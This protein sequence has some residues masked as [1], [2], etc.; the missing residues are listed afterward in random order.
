MA[1]TDTTFLNRE[2]NADVL[3]EFARVAV[4]EI[5]RLSEIVAEL[6]KSSLDREQLR[7]SYE[8]RLLKL[9]KKLFGRGG[10]SIDKGLRPKDSKDL[11]LHGGPENPDPAGQEK[12]KAKDRT[13]AREESTL[14][15]MSGPELKDE[16]MSRGYTDAKASDWEEVQGLYDQSTEITVVE[17]TYKK[18]T[19]KRKKY[20]F[21]PSIGTDKE[22]IVTAKGPEK[23]AP[24]CT[25]SLDFAIAVTCDKY[26]WHLPL[27]RQIEIMERLG[28]TGLV[29]KTLYGLID[30]LSSQVRRSGVLEKIRQDILNAPLA[31]HADETPWPVLDGHD[32][33]GYLWAICNMRGAYYRFEPSRSGKV[34]VEMLKGYSG[35]V[36]TDD[37]SGYNRLKRETSCTL[38]HCWAHA[39]RNF[40]EIS[41]N[42]TEDCRAIIHLIDEL[43]EVE[44][45]AK[46]WDQLKLLRQE[47]SES[48]IA[49]IKS[50]LEQKNAKYLL[51]EDEMGKAIRYLLNNWKEFTEFLSDIRIP[52]SNNHAERSLRHSVL[53]RKNFYGSKTING[54]DVAA[55]HYTIIETCKLLQTDPADYYRYLVAANNRGEDV[56]SPFRYVHWKYEQK[57]KLQAEEARLADAEAVPRSVNEEGGT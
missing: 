53:G 24:G 15:G 11:L 44:R 1:T 27:N 34:I 6:R 47:K 14:Y 23:L 21:K 26:Q 40:Y 3:R 39:R 9:Q 12:K 52:L 38:A 48:I 18:V 46:T 13:F 4:C 36:L 56:M 43:F 51:D 42:H 19:H 33:D 29:A 17:R 31:V 25:Y 37:F 35:P 7:L 30:M 55:D 8:D 20:R 32:S 10:E 41:G 49:R 50:W 16:A 45:Q 2:S 22:I 54:A 5:E 57:L 28:L